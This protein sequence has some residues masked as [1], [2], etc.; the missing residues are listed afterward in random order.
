MAPHLVPWP[1]AGTVAEMKA[2]KPR[3]TTPTTTGAPLEPPHPQELNRMTPLP[4]I[5]LLPG[6]RNALA[7]G[8]RVLDGHLSSGA[9]GGS[10]N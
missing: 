3:P 2:A 10:V 1:Q 8:T 6:A 4:H 5:R 7:R 9:Q